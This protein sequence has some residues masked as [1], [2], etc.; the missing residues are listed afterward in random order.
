MADQASKTINAIYT[1]EMRP[2]LPWSC[3]PARLLV[4]SNMALSQDALQFQL[5]LKPV[6]FGFSGHQTGSAI[7]AVL[8]VPLGAVSAS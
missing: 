2:L 3:S 7:L 4:K 5:D 6:V 1:Y 8:R